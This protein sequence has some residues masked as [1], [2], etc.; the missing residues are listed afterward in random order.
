MKIG[1]VVVAGVVVGILQSIWGWLTC[2]WLFNWV[3]TLEPATIW[4]SPEEM[5]FVLMNIT[6][7]VF[8]FLLA[9][10]YALVY[11]GI[12]GKGV[13]KGLWFGLIRLAGGYTSWESRIGNVYYSSSW[14][15]NL[16]DS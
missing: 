15:N 1:K 3:Y 10:V 5:P 7:L 4:K 12:P 8:A 11:K 13:V 6:N 2:G 14:N 16:L 9:L